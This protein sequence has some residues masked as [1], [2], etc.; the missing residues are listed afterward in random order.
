MGWGATRL[1]VDRSNHNDH[2]HDNYQHNDNDNDDNDNNDNEHN[3]DVNQHDNFN[4]DNDN[5]H[6]DD[7]DYNNL[8]HNDHARPARLDKVLLLGY[9]ERKH[10]A[11]MRPTRPSLTRH[12][13]ID[14]PFCRGTG[15][16]FSS[17]L[18]RFVVRLI[19]I[20]LWDVDV[21]A[22]C[23]ECKGNGLKQI[24]RPPPPSGS[25][26]TFRQYPPGTVLS[27]PEMWE[28]AQAGTLNL[29][30]D[31]IRQIYRNRQ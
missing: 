20:L 31:Q 2:D 23:P 26:P 18:H 27:I 7:N 30:P 10:G 1:C 9:G 24:L 4:D 14:C 8:N 11:V 5:E 29:T 13:S 16:R 28:I 6:N 22:K 21:Y 3:D 17:R 12:I 15:L 25:C 19:D